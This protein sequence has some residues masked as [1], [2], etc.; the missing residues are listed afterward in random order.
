MWLV[1]DDD[2]K[3]YLLGTMHALPEA[4]VWDGGA[5]ANA[6]AA[7]DALILELS[8][9][10]L[11]AAGPEFQRLA[12]RDTPLPIERR[13]PAEALA[14]YRALEASGPGRSFGG[15]TLDDW[16]VMVMMGQRAA[17]NAALD[18]ANGVETL[19]TARFRAAGKPIGGLESARGQLTMFE[20]LDAKTQRILLTHAAAGAGDAVAEVGALT[21]AWARGDVAA[22]EKMINEDV[23][24][25]P[26]A[27]AAIITDRNRRWSAWA[28]RRMDRPGTLLVAVGTGHL[29]GDDGLPALLAAAG[30]K[31]TRV[32]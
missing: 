27:R 31:V 3:L 5:V 16:A 17:Q 19:L 15:D 24:A 25:V 20:T 10:E 21:A 9:A 13:L 11:A 28:Q 26:A 1:E 2:T 18:P 12:P 30:F 8:P 6:I 4:T 23:D 7:A 32:Q 22:L 29:V 14:S